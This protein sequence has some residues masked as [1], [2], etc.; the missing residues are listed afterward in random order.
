MVFF[1]NKI[2]DKKSEKKLKK[3]F[4]YFQNLDLN[5]LKKLMEENKK[6]KDFF[7]YLNS[8]LSICKK[9][10]K[11]FSNEKILEIFSNSEDPNY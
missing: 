3:N 4:A 8:K 11:I 2:V 6:D 7:D 9:D 5:I 10:E 1:G